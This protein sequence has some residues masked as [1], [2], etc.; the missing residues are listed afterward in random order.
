MGTKRDSPGADEGKKNP[1]Q[2]VELSDEDAQKLTAQQK[3][4]ARTELALER[5][6]QQKLSVAYAKR[7][8]V[9]K[10]IPK[11]WPVAF[12]N[13]DLIAVYAQH[14]SDQ[15]ALSYL[16]DFWVNRDKDE[17]RCYT[18]EFYF[19]EN[20]FFS[21]TVLKKEYK[22]IPPPAAADEKPDEDG[23]TESNLDFSWQRDVTISG[24]PINWKDASKALTKL[25]PREKGEEDDDIPAENGSF[26]N[27]FEHED[28][29][30]DVGIVLANDIFPEA[31]E[32]FLG[33][34]EGQESDSEDEDSDDDDADEI[35]LE[36][37]RPKKRKV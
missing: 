26:F 15:L 14:G 10:T 8:E 31:I 9:V 34:A 30:F 29:P 5:V 18:L 35:D 36:K 25:Y 28:D 16:E 7:R 32:Y 20:P 2:D 22:Y 4:L 37:P 19:K 24:S 6:A 3:A 12:M 11:F 21:D 23:I 13:N 17:P 33:T 1:L 27:F